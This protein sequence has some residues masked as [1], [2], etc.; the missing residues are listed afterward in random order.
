MERTRLL[1]FSGTVRTS[2]LPTDRVCAFENR[3]KS[4]PLLNRRACLGL[5][6]ERAA[7]PIGVEHVNQV[8]SNIQLQVG[9]S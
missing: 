3:S 9:R 1:T 5:L 2:L 8:L 6:S 7:V 4:Y